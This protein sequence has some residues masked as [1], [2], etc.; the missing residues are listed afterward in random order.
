MSIFAAI[1]SARDV[2]D[3]VQILSL[4][5]LSLLFS[6]DCSV[7]TIANLDAGVEQ[8][9]DESPGRQPGARH[10]CW[11]VGAG[12]SRA[13]FTFIWGRTTHTACSLLQLF[14]C[15]KIS[16]YLILTRDISEVREANE[17]LE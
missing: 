17:S 8:F 2:D 15:L 12:W 9:F 4:P 7:L 14:L 5:S 11:L 16:F 13:T 1:S 3:R 10:R 6:L